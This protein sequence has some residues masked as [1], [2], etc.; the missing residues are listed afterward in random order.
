MLRDWGAG[1][2]ID[3]RFADMLFVRCERKFYYSCKLQKA[4]DARMEVE[5]VDPHLRCWFFDNTYASH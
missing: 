4:I 1:I 5:D 3:A 2:M